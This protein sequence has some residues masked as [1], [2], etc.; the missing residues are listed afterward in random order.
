MQRLADALGLPELALVAT[1]HPVGGFK[2]DILCTDDA[3]Q[4][5]VDNQLER[6]NHAHLRQ[7][8][9]YAAGVASCQSLSSLLRCCP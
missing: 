4:V 7:L 8:L 1:E 5:I 9:T 6:T 2:V 3:G